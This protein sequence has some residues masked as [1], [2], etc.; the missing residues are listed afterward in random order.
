MAASTSASEHMQ[1]ALPV[2]GKRAGG[3]EGSSLF[4]LGFADGLKP[5]LIG[6]QNGV[7]IGDPGYDIAGQRALG[8]I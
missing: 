5:L 4:R 7:I 1:G 8:A 3:K 2:P 6:R